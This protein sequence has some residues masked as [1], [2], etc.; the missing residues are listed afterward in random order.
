MNL[1]FLKFVSRKAFWWTGTARNKSKYQKGEKDFESAFNKIVHQG[2][3]YFKGI[4]NIECELP[5]DMMKQTID[6]T[7]PQKFIFL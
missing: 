1:L 3:L 2:V 4:K 6:L 7:F 5:A